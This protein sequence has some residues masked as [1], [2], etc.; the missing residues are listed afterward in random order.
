MDRISKENMLE[1]LTTTVAPRKRAIINGGGFNRIPDYRVMQ[2]Q[3]QIDQPSLGDL[4]KLPP[5]LLCMVL[6][7]LSCNDLEALRSCSAGAHIAVVSFPLY[8][9]L[10]AHAPAIIAILK[11]TRL[12]TSFPI[13]KIYETF[14]STCC[15]TCDQF[16]GYVFLPS[17]SRCCLHC[18]ETLLKFLPI[19]RYYAKREFG[20]S[21]K[22][23]KSLPQLR[24]IPGLFSSSS[25]DI[26]CYTQR[27]ILFSRELVEQTSDLKDTSLIQYGEEHVSHDT[28]K[29][30]QRHMALTPLPSFIPKSASTENGVYCAGCALRAK[31]HPPYYGLIRRGHSHP[32]GIRNVTI[33]RGGDIH[34]WMARTIENCFLN[35]AQEKLYDSRHFY[36]HF[37]GCAAAQDL[38]KHKWT[39]SQK[40]ISGANT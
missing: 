17:F 26:K 16:G 36:S 35:T 4:G 24:T 1:W 31:E 12:A 38:F 6:G 7:H 3:R 2:L 5:E 40:E 13:T 25:G 14:A 39:E 22:V 19:S 23:L 15:T 20:V 29:A 27:L 34:C 10:C 11:K 8:R 30:Y 37:Q 28:I 33:T 18:A 32:K 9:T 21:E